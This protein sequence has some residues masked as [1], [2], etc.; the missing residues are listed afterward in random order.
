MLIHAH[1]KT[2]LG[3]LVGEWQIRK[4]LCILYIKS[5]TRMTTKKWQVI[6]NVSEDVGKSQSSYTAGG[7][8]KCWGY[9]GKESG[10][11]SKC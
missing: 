11:A 5:P 9:F 6:I 1:Q 2:P 8:V 4:K 3:K 7:N 10:G